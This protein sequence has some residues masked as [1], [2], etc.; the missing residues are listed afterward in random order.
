MFDFLALSVWHAEEDVEHVHQLRVSARRAEAAVETFRLV[1]PPGKARKVLKGLRKLRRA[2]APA[3]ELDVLQGRL[4]A[5]R[6]GES[7]LMSAGAWQ[8]LRAAIVGQRQLA[9]EALKEAYEQ[10]MA[11]GLERRAAELVR[12][13][14]WRS[15]IAQP[16]WSEVARELLLPAVDQWLARCHQGTSV[17]ELHRFRIACK[18]LRYRTELTASGLHE[19]V[20][21]KVY[22]QLRDIQKHLGEMNDHDCMAQL[23]QHLANGDTPWEPF[24]LYL[25]QQGEH[26]AAAFREWWTAQR[27]NAFQDDLNSAIGAT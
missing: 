7:G 21:T 3:R 9:Q 22:P 12:R 6:D 24:R 20:R 4:D 11:R 19:T 1:L 18:K 23:V 16:P 5:P 14:R 17:E 10:E 2:A 25:H 13:I 27:R 26:S 8:A 15:A